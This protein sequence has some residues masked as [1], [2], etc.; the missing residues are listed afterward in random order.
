MTVIL[1]GTDFGV[2]GA[3]T[4]VSPANRILDD[5]ANLLDIIQWRTLLDSGQVV[6]QAEVA[7]HQGITRARVTQ[8]MGLVRLAPEIREH[9]LSMSDTVR[10]PA[11]TE[12][13]LRPT[14]RFEDPKSQFAEFELLLEE[15]GANP[16]R[17]GALLSAQ[18]DP[19]VQCPAISRRCR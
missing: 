10:R 9:I 6:S 5:N 18:Q 12:R 16:T 4:V 1:A 2:D 17:C 19:R 8:I 3:G 13:A 7:R 15:S 14:A 11:V